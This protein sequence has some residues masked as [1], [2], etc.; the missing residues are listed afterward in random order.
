MPAFE[1]A[2][3]GLVKGMSAITPIAPE[4]VEKGIRPILTV[5]FGTEGGSGASGPWSPL[6]EAYAA[7]KLKRWGAKPILVASGRLRDSLLGD[8]GDTI[9]NYS[10]HLIEFG[11]SVSYAMPHQ[12]GFRTRATGAP[13]RK[14]RAAAR[15]VKSFVEARRMFDW[16][17]E[18]RENLRTVITRALIG[19]LQRL[20]YAVASK[21]GQAVTPAQ[22]R[23]LGSQSL[24]G[25]AIS[26][27]V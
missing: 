12:T 17:Q 14:A 13:S 22:A 26:G 19:Y 5:Q 9:K 15:A 4:I 21:T 27:S 1:L 18:D 2:M 25:L 11:T 8:T 16:T 20:G 3:A 7:A 24:A 6:S 23:L 10:P